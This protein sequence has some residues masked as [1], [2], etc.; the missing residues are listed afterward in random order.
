MDCL[1]EEPCPCYGAG[2]AAGK[3]K[4]HFELVESQEVV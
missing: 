4:A 3:D 1:H 2:Y